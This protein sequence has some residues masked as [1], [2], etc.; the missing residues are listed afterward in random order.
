M[1]TQKNYVYYTNV[2][3]YIIHSLFYCKYAILNTC[4]Y[5][6]VIKNKPKENRNNKQ[7]RQKSE[8]NQNYEKKQ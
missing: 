1:Q 8:K 3:S 2:K 5:K 4:R 7:V 6:N